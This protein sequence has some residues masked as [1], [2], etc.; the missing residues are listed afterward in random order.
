MMLVNQNINNSN[1]HFH[2]RKIDMQKKN[3]SKRNKNLNKTNFF[4]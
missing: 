1:K 2:E 4:F 3:L